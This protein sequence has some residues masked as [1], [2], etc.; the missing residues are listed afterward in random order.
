M[1]CVSAILILTDPSIIFHPLLLTITHRD[2]LTSIIKNSILE[3]KTKHK[4]VYK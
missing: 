3:S 2:Q 4:K 1:S